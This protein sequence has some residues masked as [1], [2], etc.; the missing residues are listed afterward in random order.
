M[1]QQPLYWYIRK[2]V[3]IHEDAEDIL[4]ETLIKAYRHL[5]TLRSDEALRSWLFK[6]ATNEIRRHFKRH[7]ESVPL[8]KIPE[9]EICNPAGVSSERATE[10]ISS[11]F[12]HMSPL[13]REVFCLRCWEDLGYEEI[14][15]ITGSSIN[16]LMVSYHEARKKIEKAV[17]VQLGLEPDDSPADFHS[18]ERSEEA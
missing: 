6:I 14:S 5:W 1:Y 4:Q 11:A 2:V 8:E 15:R 18:E 17:A 3:L 12:L 16:T 9:P 13:Q 10:V 7:R